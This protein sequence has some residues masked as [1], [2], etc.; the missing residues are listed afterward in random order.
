M[1][2]QSSPTPDHH[3]QPAPDTKDWT[4]TIERA[5]PECGADVSAL[6]P[7]DIA[8]AVRTCLPRWATVL[9][10]E[11]VAVRPEPAVWSPLE[12]AAHV[13]DVFKVMHYRLDLMHAQDGPTFPDWDQDATALEDGYAHQSPQVI[14]TQLAAAGRGLADAFD[15]V[16]KRDLNRTGLRGNGAAFTVETLARYTWHD[17][18]HH[19][20]D[21]N[22]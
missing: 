11:D 1:T 22:G 17:I 12:Y 8:I 20:H 14:S 18:V 10:R 19:L 9:H 7:Q 16:L 13:R 15:S 21:V 6:S 4:W 5:C 2:S 3:S